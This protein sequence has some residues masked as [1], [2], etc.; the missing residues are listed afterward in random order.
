ML[1]IFSSLI[2]TA[3]FF[4]PASSHAGPAED[5]LDTFQ[6]PANIE[7]MKQKFGQKML[8]ATNK[9]RSWAPTKIPSSKNSFSNSLAPAS[10]VPGYSQP[11]VNGYSSSTYTPEQLQA[12]SELL[13]LGQDPK[14]PLGSAVGTFFK[15]Q[16]ENR[17]ANSFCGD[18]GGN[19]IINCE[20]FWHFSTSWQNN[21]C[22]VDASAT[23]TVTGN[24]PYSFTCTQGPWLN[25]TCEGALATYWTYT[26]YALCQH[27]AL[28]C[29]PM[30]SNHMIMQNYGAW[31][32][33]AGHSINDPNCTLVSE[34]VINPDGRA[35]R[36]YDCPSDPTVTPNYSTVDS[37][38][39]YSSDPSYVYVSEICLDSAPRAISGYSIS[40]P[41]SCWSVQKT[42]KKKILNENYD[43]SSCTS[44]KAAYQK[45]T[46]K[47]ATCLEPGGPKTVDTFTVNKDCYRWSK[48]YVCGGTNKNCKNTDP[49]I[50]NTRDI[51]DGKNATGCTYTVQDVCVDTQTVTKTIDRNYNCTEF[52]PI[53]DKAQ[54]CKF[55]RS[56]DYQITKAVKVFGGKKADATPPC[57]EFQSGSASIYFTG[58]NNHIMI[59]DAGF[60]VN[61]YIMY[62]VLDVSV[63]RPDGT[64]ATNR[65]VFGDT[66]TC[67]PKS[68]D[69][70]SLLQV[71]MNTI[72]ISAKGG[73]S[74]ST[75]TVTDA[76]PQQ[77]NYVI[78]PSC[79]L[80]NGRVV[81][82]AANGYTS[83]QIANSPDVECTISRGQVVETSDVDFFWKG[84]TKIYSS[85]KSASVASNPSPGGMFDFIVTGPDGIVRSIIDRQGS[86]GIDLTSLFRQGLNHVHYSFHYA[87][88]DRCGHEN[89]STQPLVPYPYDQL[90]LVNYTEQPIDVTNTGSEVP[91]T[92]LVNIDVTSDPLKDLLNDP[93]CPAYENNPD[94][95]IKNQTCA[96]DMGS[97]D[98]NLLTSTGQCCKAKTSTTASTLCPTCGSSPQVINDPTSGAVSRVLSPH[99]GPTNV[100]AGPDGYFISN[101]VINYNV[102]GNG[103]KIYYSTTKDALTGG[104]T[105]LNQV[106]IEVIWPDG[107]IVKKT[108]RDA[109]ALKDIT[110]LFSEGNNKV[111]FFQMVK[112]N[113]KVSAY[114]TPTLFIVT[115]ADAP[116]NITKTIAGVACFDCWDWTNNYQCVDTSAFDTSACD[117]LTSKPGCSL[118]SENCG[119]RLSSGLC[120]TKNKTFN[121]PDQT[122]QTV[123]NKYETQTVASPGCLEL[124]CIDPNNCF[125][126]SPQQDKNQGAVYA[127]LASAAQMQK[128]WKGFDIDHLR[129]FNA[130]PLECRNFLNISAGS[131]AKS[132]CDFENLMKL[133]VAGAKAGY[134]A[135]TT[136]KEIA[137]KVIEKGGRKVLKEYWDKLINF[138]MNGFSSFLPSLDPITLGLLATEIGWNMWTKCVD[139]EYTLGRND[140]AGLIHYVGD[141]CAIPMLVG[142][143]ESHEVYCSFDTILARIIN[144][145]G[146]EQIGKGWGTGDSPDCDGFKIEE[147]QQIDFAKIDYT[148][149]IDNLIEHTIDQNGLSDLVQTGVKNYFDTNKNNWNQ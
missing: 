7:M 136:G 126:T 28:I 61:P 37:C 54:S 109:P 89:N 47:K 133:I 145:Q 58:G 87:S 105:T 75:P 74:N 49:L 16:F 122:T 76:C 66:G 108:F 134:W 32:C 102:I 59:S 55:T 116:I 17:P 112:P 22:T 117:W 83:I 52:A 65:F 3:L 48:S 27:P 35:S 36:V 18:T 92:W 24:P 100:T 60:T 12:E 6:S 118:V 86:D 146:R 14:N 111:E 94:C 88:T 125:K 11:A 21:T 33:D 142:Y 62:E 106:R 114:Y 67:Q 23:V 44:Q 110:G 84:D 96:T 56:V 124:Y 132:C 63:L 64:T 46:P 73:C 77:S 30:D 149:F 85:E 97:C 38:A 98:Q 128:D 5:A 137:E 45:C 140:A 79:T 130:K 2:L 68:I 53:E 71:G 81:Q 104:G 25:C 101:S 107:T 10:M 57:S 78:C 40:P 69:L 72:T 141:R 95:A 51:Q 80:G 120:Q 138:E 113:A 50:S 42:Y 121:C 127:Y 144:E 123:C 43:A 70:T 82:D 103:A 91:N 148:E 131:Q 93:V 20:E 39:S 129:I 119:Y 34:T 15:D 99:T 8:D 29:A 31:T 19:K 13:L 90:W 115:Y 9:A 26:D 41:S 135:A 4:L 147:L 1:K 143:A 139:D